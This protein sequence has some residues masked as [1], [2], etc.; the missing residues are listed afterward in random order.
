[1]AYIPEPISPE[2]AATRE[3]YLRMP[4]P[5]D[6]NPYLI[7]KYRIFATGDRWVTLSF[8]EGWDRYGDA[9]V[10]PTAL[11]RR[12]MAEANVLY[13]SRPVITDHELLAGNLDLPEYTPEEQARYEKLCDEYRM[14]NQTLLHR[15][16]RKDHIG[17]DF[18]KLL[19][20]GLQGI[21]R[22]IEK[23]KAGLDLTCPSLPEQMEVMRKLD[24]YECCRVELEAVLDLASRYEK[25]LREKAESAGPKRRAELL[26]MADALARVPAQPANGFFEAVQS[27]HFFLSTLFGLYPLCRPDRYLYP[28]YK[29]DLDAGRITRAEAQKLID[30]F[31]LGIS[32]RVFTRAAC[33]F[34]VGGRDADGSVTENDLT[35]MFLTALEHVRLPDPNGA[36]AV[37]RDTSDEILAYAGQILA[38]G[39]THPAFYNDEVISAAMQ[40]YGVT[41]EDSVNYIHCTCAEM[42]ISGKSRPQTTCVWI[43]L[44]QLLLRAARESDGTSFECLRKG[45]VKRISETLREELLKYLMHMLEVSRNGNE[46]MRVSCLIDGC[47]ETGRSIF[48]GGARYNF[49][50]P[51]FI[52]FS[53]AVD[54]LLA[55]RRLVYEEKRLT[56]R[57]YDE[58]VR[59]NFAGR[60][61][62][63]QYALNSVPHYG[64]DD[65]E[66]DEMAKWLGT[67]IRDLCLSTPLPGG[68]HVM[69]GTFSYVTHAQFGAK[70]GATYDGRLAGVS[71]SDGCGPVQ[72]RDVCGPTAMV[73]SLTSWDQSRFMSGMVINVKFSPEHLRP[74]NPEILTA[75]VRAF[76]QRGGVEMQVNVVDKETLLDARVHPEKH[77]DL[78]VRIGGY[79]DYFI[80]LTDTMQAEICARTEY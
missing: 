12:S 17:L 74:D 71:Y 2:I 77:E 26:R 48:E 37:C 46:P 29:R 28:Y 44:P 33:G 60:E 7:K 16:P 53:T 32:T 67:E 43:D 56:Q 49:L 69:A 35:W 23:K 4:V 39:V 34:I 63:R 19:R 24:F 9:D 73:N 8:L 1:M 64:N 21:L 5:R 11:L 55:L 66:A 76:M 47:L 18:E 57:E 41:P 54:S 51:T 3:E 68:K 40:T 62:L 38:K 75:I 50:Q 65:P 78:I 25:A 6:T 79:S 15:N 59:S 72:G 27:A 42:G 30:N 70:C 20:V 13:A 61:A 36:L 31:C 45:F 52:G 22:E 10:A 58:L 14:S 80:R